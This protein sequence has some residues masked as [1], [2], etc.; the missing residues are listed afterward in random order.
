M[1]DPVDPYLTYL[2]A[3]T[4]RHGRSVSRAT[5]RAARADLHGFMRWWERTHR[6]TFDVPLVL[7]RDPRDWQEHR[8]V[9][10]GAKPATINRASASLR[11][12]FA[13]AQ[14]VQMISYNP[15][16]GLHDLPVDDVAPRGVPAAG[17]EWLVRVASAQSNP[18]ARHRDLALLTLLSDCGL[19]SQEAADVQLRD[20]DLDGAQLIVRSGKGRTPRRVP[21]TTTA[22]RRLHD[23]LTVRCPT[24]SGVVG[25]DAEREPLLVG[26]HIT[27][28]GQPWEPGL[29]PV[30]IRKRV[31]ELG[32][33]AAQRVTGHAAKESSVTRVAELTDL[34]GKLKVVSPHQLRHGLAYRLLK[35]GATPAYVQKVLGHSRVSTSLMYGKPTEDDIRDALERTDRLTRQGEN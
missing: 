22:I 31:A 32:G 17:V 19:R 8:Q 3:R 4:N 10:D 35:H 18:M 6:L 2:S 30:A 34:A 23:Y 25:S 12:F 16:A 24:D 28:V 26:R 9:V 5:I 27:K 21:L 15:A 20:L 7:D 14:A 33:A 1:P 11:A 13:W 29:T